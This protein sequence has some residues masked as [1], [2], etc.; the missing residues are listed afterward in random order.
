[1]RKQHHKPEITFLGHT[2]STEG[3]RPL[4][5]RAE[6][7]KNLEKATTVSGLEWR[8]Q[9]CLKVQNPVFE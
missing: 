4:K 6:P 8:E 7:I 3:G 2:V 1:M 5:P 9:Q